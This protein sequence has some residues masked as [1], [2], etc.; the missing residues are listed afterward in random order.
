MP[1]GVEKLNSADHGPALTRL[2]RIGPHVPISSKIRD[3]GNLLHKR[4]SISSARWSRNHSGPA[5]SRPA[6]QRALAEGA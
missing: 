6:D 4:L 2:H 3:R 5:R 1:S